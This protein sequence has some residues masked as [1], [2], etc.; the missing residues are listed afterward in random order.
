MH[1]TLIAG[2]PM[3]S[4]LKTVLV[5]GGTGFIGKKLCEHFL[6]S[7]YRVYVLTR[8]KRYA[9]HPGITN[10]NDLNE[11][12]QIDIDVIINLAGETISKRWTKK[13]K[14]S[15]YSSRIVTTRCLVDSMRPKQNRPKLLISASAIG[16]YG[17]HPHAV[18]EE[19]SDIAM[20]AS[21]FAHSLCSAWEEEAKRAEQLGVR[22]I[23]L[24]IG[25]VLEKNGGVLSKLLPS[26]YSGLGGQMGDGEQWFSWIDRDDLIN[27]ISFLILNTQIDG[28]VN[29]TA[30]YPVTNRTF[31]LALAKAIHRPCF[32]KMP[33]IIFKLLFG[34]MADEIMLK[35]QKVI[36]KKA[37][38]HGFNFSYPTLQQSLE[39]IFRL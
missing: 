11:L 26:F 8:S 9:Q 38:A 27:L 7:G 34:E 29:A 32:L 25:P 35:G 19:E 23:L 14:A 22:V 31:S 12:S 5:T 15:M 1:A 37:L 17:T 18:F 13:N 30:P 21:G 10:V 20:T 2:M 24:R 4:E 6:T 3:N 33:R 28:P 39:K 36:P 16:Y